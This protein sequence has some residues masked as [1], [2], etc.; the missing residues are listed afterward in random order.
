[1][2]EEGR[3]GRRREKMKE[4]LQIPKRVE[5]R[6]NEKWKE[7]LS[8]EKKEDKKTARNCEP[9]TNSATSSHMWMEGGD[10]GTRGCFLP[11]VPHLPTVS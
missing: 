7:K 9:R 11:A 6:G 10:R 3:I 4:K 5:E 1:M 2:A 8:R